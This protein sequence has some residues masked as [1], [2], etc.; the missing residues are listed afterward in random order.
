MNKTKQHMDQSKFRQINQK[1]PKPHD[2]P[3]K[4]HKNNMF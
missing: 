2:Q 1:I 4:K 3:K